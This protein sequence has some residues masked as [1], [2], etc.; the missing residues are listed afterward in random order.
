MNEEKELVEQFIAGDDKAF[1]EIV[2][3]FQKQIY[4]HARRMVGNHMEADEVT[5]EVLLAIYNNLK[6]FNFNSS[7]ST[8][9]YSITQRRSINELRKRKS[10]KILFLG[11]E[12]TLGLKSKKDII[13]EYE[14]KEKLEQVENKLKKLSNK[15]REVFIFRQYDGLSYSEISEITGKSIGALKANYFHALKKIISYLDETSAAAG[16]NEKD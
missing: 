14:A 8:W 1:N 5:Q 9:I 7:L 6:S 3:K 10:K 2:R 13:I 16:N 11:D 12:N 15:Q 4:W